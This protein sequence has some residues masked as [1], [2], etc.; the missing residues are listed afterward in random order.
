M[1]GDHIKGIRTQRLKRNGGRKKRSAADTLREQ[2]L[3]RESQLVWVAQRE[4][5]KPTKDEIRRAREAQGQLLK[6]WTTAI[7]NAARRYCG[8]GRA[9]HDYW[10]LFQEGCLGFL[11]GLEK[12]DAGRGYWLWTYVEHWVHAFMR[13]WIIKDRTMRIGTTQTERSL[14]W[15]IGGV[16]AKREAELGP[17]AKPFVVQDLVDRLPESIRNPKKGPP[18][19]HEKL[20]KSVLDF[21]EKRRSIG[22]VQSLDTSIRSSKGR[23]EESGDLFVSALVDKGESVTSVLEA[24]ER[25]EAL[26]KAVANIEKTLNARE[27][28][29]LRRRI[30]AE[31]PETFRAIGAQFGL[32]RERIRQLEVAIIRRLR[33]EYFRL[34]GELP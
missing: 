21:M 23:A 28:A 1:S 10:G 7:G 16:E 4:E 5:R 9:G 19:S 14:F 2:T 20:R 12:Y 8:D 13:N 26:R 29:V 25:A 27:K 22:I 18:R 31:N 30:L 24:E 3:V 15:I 33:E 11:H 17:E 6:Q 34:G 32:S